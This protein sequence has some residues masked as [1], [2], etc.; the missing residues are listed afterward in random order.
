MPQKFCGYLLCSKC[1]LIQHL[2]HNATINKVFIES[3]Q[4]SNEKKLYQLS[5][6]HIWCLTSCI[7][8]QRASG[9]LLKVSMFSICCSWLLIAH[10]VSALCFVSNG[11]NL[12]T[13][14]LTTTDIYLTH[15]L[16]PKAWPWLTQPGLLPWL[17][18]A[19]DHC[20]TLS[21]SR[22]VQR[23][24]EQINLSKRE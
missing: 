3:F 14:P 24:K 6:F 1:W 18:S 23:G 7:N 22:S 13:W 17:N 10:L 2:P 19:T 15:H 8:V 11:M 5:V 21:N 20:P 4:I 16:V 12:P 9:T